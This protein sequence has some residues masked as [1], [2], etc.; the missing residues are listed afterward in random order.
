MLNDRTIMGEGV[1]QIQKIIDYVKEAGF[2]GYNEVEIFSNHHW[3]EDQ[4]IFLDKIVQ[5]Y[6]NYKY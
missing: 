2:D 4:D 1:I 5:A 3:A 6:S